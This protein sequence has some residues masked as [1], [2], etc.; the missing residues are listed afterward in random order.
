MA[1][2]LCFCSPL[3]MYLQVCVFMTVFL[4]MGGWGGGGGGLDTKLYSVTIQNQPA[5]E[6]IS[7]RETS[8]KLL[9]LHERSGLHWVSD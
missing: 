6:L 9:I 3:L 7:A 4:C 5:R 1:G 8:H 2:W